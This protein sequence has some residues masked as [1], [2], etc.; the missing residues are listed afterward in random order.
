MAVFPWKMFQVQKS[1]TC[2]FDFGKCI[3][4]IARNAESSISI[5]Y[6]LAETEQMRYQTVLKEKSDG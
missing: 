5:K 4:Y 3:D 1:K 2:S 6:P